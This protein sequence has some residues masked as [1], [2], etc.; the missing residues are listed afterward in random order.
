MARSRD[1][2]VESERTPLVREQTISD[3]D[4][5]DGLHHAE[6]EAGS[7]VTSLDE[8]KHLSTEIS[9]VIALLLLGV[10]VANADTSLVLATYSSISSEFL[11]FEQA[12]WLLASYTLA[13]CVSQP[14]YGKL[15]N[16]FGRKSCLLGV[17]VFFMVGCLQC[18]VASSMSGVIIGRAIGGVG[19]AGISSIVSFLIADL[20]P[21]AEI[22]T[23]R[24]YVN[25]VQTM[26][27]ASGGPLGGWLA[28]S[29][30]WRW[31]FL[32]QCPLT[33]SAFLLVQWKLRQHRPV[34]HI[35]GSFIQQLKRVDILGSLLI[36]ASNVAGLLPMNLGG[37]YRWNH[38][39]VLA[40][41]GS[42]AAT[43]IL[44][45]VVELQMVKE[46]IFHLELL[47]NRNFTLSYLVMLF[48]NVAQTFVSFSFCTAT[49]CELT[50]LDDV[51]SALVLSDYPISPST[52]G[53]YLVP[54]V[55][56]NTIGGL[57]C[58]AYIRRFG[59]YKAPTIFATIASA[60]CHSLL[61][62]RW[63]GSTGVLESLYIVLGWMGTGVSHSSIF[64]ALVSAVTEEEVAIAGSGLY[65]FSSLRSV[66]GFTLSSNLLRLAT[67]TWAQRQLGSKHQVII[68]RALSDIVFAQRLKGDLKTAITDAYLHGFHAVFCT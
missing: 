24:S 30:G 8:T 32:I 16:I 56:G 34:F 52:A 42:S 38:P 64:I 28:Q 36:S 9:S 45:I 31:S 35:E 1:T 54:A 43:L 63:R 48:Q 60:A 66:L 3:Q 20:V 51:Y 11:E 68:N 26:G 13:M 67:Q 4:L 25:I 58:G 53:T 14:L 18:G 46:P 62:L 17:Y 21:L 12:S 57:A 44:F 61:L 29:L 40:L 65:L 10:F 6:E 22:A 5:H 37:D 2:Y 39:I 55:V 27:R 23:Y 50:A 7:T 41:F 47:V 49:Y 59:S 15:C 19:G 33:L